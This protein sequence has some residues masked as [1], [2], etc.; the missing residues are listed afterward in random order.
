MRAF[1]TLVLNLPGFPAPV[2]WLT[3]EGK[4]YS[5]FPGNSF[6]KSSKAI[7]NLREQY[8]LKYWRAGPTRYLFQG[9]PPWRPFSEKVSLQTSG[10][11]KYLFFLNENSSVAFDRPAVEKAKWQKAIA[12]IPSIGFLNSAGTAES[13]LCLI[14]WSLCF[15]MRIWRLILSRFGSSSSK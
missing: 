11:N 6:S 14:S 10:V 12:S 5:A 1:L 13:S 4:R 8:S 2:S 3:N 15:T 7:L 9:F